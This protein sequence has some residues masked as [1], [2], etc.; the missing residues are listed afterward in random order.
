MLHQVASSLS[1]FC[2][3][4]E[5]VDLFEFYFTNSFCFSNYVVRS[6]KSSRNILEGVFKETNV[7]S[8]KD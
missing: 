8:D 2:N 1:S 6:K 7:N 3:S 5:V 4:L